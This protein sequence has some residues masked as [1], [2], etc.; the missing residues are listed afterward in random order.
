MK[1]VAALVA[2][3]ACVR[4]AAQPTTDDAAR[5]FERGVTFDQFLAKASAQRDVWLR[6][7]SDGEVDRE[8]VQRLTRAG[9]GLRL[10]VVAEDWCVDSAHTVPYVARLAAA[11]R[12]ELRIVDRDV[13]A[14]LMARHPTRDGRPATP[15][16]VL[17]REGR[18]VGAW[19]ERPAP[20]QDLFFSMAT[21][22]ESAKR[23]ADRA[24]WYD[25]DR[26][27]TTI[28]ELLALAAK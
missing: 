5:L 27:R 24:S 18:D 12:V 11:S 13:G 21:N 7:A 2:V 4:L 10:L 15:T 6:T 17:I 25:A 19:I 20:L 14:P 28:A 22:P 3:A 9:S 26:G 1:R 8:A 23:F 16:I